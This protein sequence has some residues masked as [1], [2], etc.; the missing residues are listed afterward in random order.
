MNTPSYKGTQES[1]LAGYTAT[2][3]E[4]LKEWDRHL[5]ISATNT[6]FVSG[7]SEPKNY[8]DEDDTVFALK[9]LTRF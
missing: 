6:H 2:P 1:V 9:E 8:K 3:V 7:A 4:M 5:A